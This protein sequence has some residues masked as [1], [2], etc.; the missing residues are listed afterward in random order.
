MTGRALRSR[1]VKAPAPTVEKGLE[2]PVCQSSVSF[3]PCCQ[4]LT[5]YSFDPSSYII[6]YASTKFSAIYYSPC[7]LNDLSMNPLS[8]PRYLLSR[9]TNISASRIT[10]SYCV[11]TCVST[12][13]Q[14]GAIENKT[15]SD[16]TVPSPTKTPP[17]LKRPAKQAS[18]SAKKQKRTDIYDDTE[19]L[20]QYEKSPLFQDGVNIKA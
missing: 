17:N 19:S 4:A 3:C 18:R 6:Y 10:F 14:P 2:D 20:L 7:F 5:C 8:L 1:P 13:S 11:L 15:I 16:H 9:E 12:Q